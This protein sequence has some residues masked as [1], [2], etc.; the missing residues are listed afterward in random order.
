[1]LQYSNII[2]KCQKQTD[3]RSTEKKGPPYIASLC[4]GK[5]K[6][7]ND[8]NNYESKP[9]KNGKYRWIKVNSTVKKS[10]KK[11]SKKS[12]KKS[13]KKSTKKSPKKSTKKS[14]S[15]EL[16]FESEGDSDGE[17]ILTENLSKM[18]ARELKKKAVDAGIYSTIT[19][20]DGKK[21][22]PLK[23]D[24]IM[25][26]QGTQTGDTKVVVLTPKKSPG[27]KIRM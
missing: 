7:G 10:T 9:D 21:G 24:I 13:S 1:M 12:T 15:V 19:R 22:A 27:R 5:I 17:I 4:P 20:Q 6:T 26:L 14:P 25:A 16:V 18:T 3:K 23:S 11:S 2:M 8:G